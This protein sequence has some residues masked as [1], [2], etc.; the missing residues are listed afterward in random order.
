M[1][2]HLNLPGAVT[3]DQLKVLAQVVVGAEAHF[4]DLH[5]SSLPSKV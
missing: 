3:F 4:D 5:K 2:T 1:F